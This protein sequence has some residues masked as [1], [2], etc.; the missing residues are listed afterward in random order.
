MSLSLR[1]RRVRIYGYDN[2]GG[3]G[4]VSSRYTFRDERWASVTQVSSDKRQLG[5]APETTTDAVFDFD[6]SVTVN[7]NDLLVDGDDRYFARGITVQGTPS[8]KVVRGQKLSL[9]VFQKL[10][11]VD[12]SVPTALDDPTYDDSVVES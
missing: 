7:A 3:D 1:N 9:E 12:Y 6:P 2:S 11:I 4:F 8:A 5:T 10:D